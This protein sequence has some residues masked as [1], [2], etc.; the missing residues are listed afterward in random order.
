MRFVTLALLVIKTHATEK[1]KPNQ[2][3]ES[4]LECDAGSF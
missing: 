1:F 2:L 3:L 4:K